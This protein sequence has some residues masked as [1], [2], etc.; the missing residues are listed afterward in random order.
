LFPRRWLIAAILAF[1]A[2]AAPAAPEHPFLVFS[3]AD[4]PALRQRANAEP[5]LAQCL[6]MVQ[7]N[8]TQVI[9]NQIGADW[10]EKL[11]AQAFLAMLTGDPAQK[12]EATREML[13]ALRSR[14]PAAFYR[15][16][17]FHSLAVPLRAL[18]LA[19]DWLSPSMTAAQRVEA[20][21][22]LERWCLAAMEDTNRQWWREG[23]YNVGAI[24]VSGIG[25]LAVALSG[26]S[27]NAAVAA[28]RREAVRRIRQNYFPRTWRAS[29]ICYEGPC[30]AIVGLKYAAFLAQVEARAGGED[31]LADSGA[32][33]AMSYLMYQYMPAGG[34]APIGDNTGYNRKTFAAEYLLCLG[35]T[36]DAAGLWTWRRYLRPEMLD[37]LVTYLWYPLDLTPVRPS[38]AGVP[39]S[40]YFEVAPNRAG[41]LFGRSAW[42]DRNAA[43]FA[44]VTR[45]D[46]CNH[47]H[48]DMNSF[49]FG[50][51]GTLFATHRMLYPY[52]SARHGVDYEHNLV[53]VNGGGWPR[54]NRTTSCHDD[55]AT[56]GLLMG[57]A[58]S[59]FADYVRG[60]ARWSYRDNGFWI[61]NPALRAE[62]ACLFV[63]HATTPYLV[64]LDDLE[65]HG[66][67]ARFEWLWHAPPV[68]VRGVAT[69]Q[70][71]LLLV[72]NQ[73]SCA[74]Q[75]VEPARPGLS[76]GE[77]EQETE[78]PGRRGEALLRIR[79]EQQGARVRFA[80][81]ASVQSN[82]AARPLVSAQA[83]TCRSP[84]AGGARVS[85]ADGAQDTVAWQSEE[86][87]TQRGED[88]QAGL[89]RTDGLAALVRVQAGKVT[90]FVLGEGTY[91]E[92]GGTNLVRAS[93]PVCV[94][95]GLTD[96]QVTG[97]RRSRQGLP[98]VMPETLQVAPLPVGL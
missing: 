94:S 93:S 87:R 37:A 96:R 48:Y 70:E 71:P 47:Q 45:F 98:P 12:Q 17:E 52:P 83:V 69:L 6:L 49:L 92:W 41:Y 95:A 33:H 62:R 21:P 18:A 9:T 10:A 57:V 79:V 60:D 20:L 56:D 8:A 27:T 54:T 14:D 38:T 39:T 22:A 59:E 84:S 19:W 91:L 7:S 90:G 55:N 25:I 32:L 63:K 29:G 64:V 50:G 2:P 13:A 85:L 24:P 34:C 4:L 65:F 61:D 67:P 30:Y 36:R 89:L 74:I 72:T 44:F 31:L 28:C 66:Q 46:N 43:F 73:A 35:R 3:A 86:E 51:Y 40:Q 42:E 53:I 97:R 11:E 82:L 58:L 78:R 5:L 75:F 68:E 80:A 88:L 81:V 15:T 26:D 76:V 16:S 23:S 1:L 77:A